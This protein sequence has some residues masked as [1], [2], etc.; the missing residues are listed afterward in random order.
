[1]EAMTKVESTQTINAM[2]LWQGFVL[3][4]GHQVTYFYG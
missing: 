2:T 1:M 4:R 3:Y